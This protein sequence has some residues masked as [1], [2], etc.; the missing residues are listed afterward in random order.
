MKWSIENMKRQIDNGLVVEVS[1]RVIGE[2]DGC[3]ADFLGSV[4]LS[5]DPMQPNFIPFDDLTEELVLQWVK[6]L[7]DVDVIE[8][9]I[10]SKI[11]KKVQRKALRKTVSGLPWNH[12][13]FILSYGASHRTIDRSIGLLTYLS[14]Y[15]VMWSEQHHRG[16]NC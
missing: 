16:Q 4:L 10:L 9:V 14:Q 8:S 2:M 11:D 1:Y 5:G 15:R 12:G 6:D 3:I 13:P 7:V